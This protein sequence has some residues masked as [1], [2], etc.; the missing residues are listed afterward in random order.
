MNRIGSSTGRK[1]LRYAQVCIW[2][3]TLA[4]VYVT[5]VNE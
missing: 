4:Y 5:D 2:L 1:R 3:I